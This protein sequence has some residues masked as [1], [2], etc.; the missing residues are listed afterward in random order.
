MVVY[1]TQP[2]CVKTSNGAVTLASGSSCAVGSDYYGYNGNI[3]GTSWAIST[4][5]DDD[6]DVPG[7]V[8]RLGPLDR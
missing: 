4:P 1:A 6:G 8:F 5:P 3:N 2:F 7:A